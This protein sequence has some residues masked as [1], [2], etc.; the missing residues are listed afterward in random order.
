MEQNKQIP[1]TVLIDELI[2]NS[3][4]TASMLYN[5]KDALMK[6]SENIKKL[7]DE[8]K[9]LKKEKAGDENNGLSQDK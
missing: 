6:A 8:I 9:E 5:I 4:N 2:R 1:V 7:E 3:N